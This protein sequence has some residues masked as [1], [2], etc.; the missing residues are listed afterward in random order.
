LYSICPE[1][2]LVAFKY[3]MF[4]VFL[5]WLSLETCFSFL[6]LPSLIVAWSHDCV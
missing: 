6:G 5:S 4:F 3:D 2:T 1:Y